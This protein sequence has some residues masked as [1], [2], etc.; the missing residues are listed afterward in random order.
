MAHSR[1]RVAGI[2]FFIAAAQF[3]IALIIAEALYPG[4][5]ISNNYISDLG[6]GPSSFIFNSSVFL[7]GLLLAAGTYMLGDIKELKTSKILLYLTAIGAIG[8]GIFTEDSPVPHAIASMITFLF[9]GIAAIMSARTLKRPLSLI[10]I[11]MGAMTLGALGLFAI[12]P[13][14]SGTLG[15][16]AR[17]SFFYLGL[18]PGGM[19]RMVVYPGLMWL[20]WFSGHLS[21]K[22]K[23]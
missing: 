15:G 7:V 13:I 22:G 5:S 2:L 9:G 4:Y 6:V 18:G 17:D 16:S 23:Q 21:T 3:V 20:T 11:I 19:E 10:G 14:I 8:V 1:E 12:G